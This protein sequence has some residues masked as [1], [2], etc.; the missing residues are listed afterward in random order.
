ME[1]GGQIMMKEG[2]LLTPNDG[3]DNLE[4]V[5]KTVRFDI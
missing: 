1:D 4:E 5:V 3:G 2:E